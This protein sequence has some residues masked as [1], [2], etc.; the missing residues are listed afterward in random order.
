[1]YDTATLVRHRAHLSFPVDAAVQWLLDAQQEDGG[2][3]PRQVGY[4][5]DVPTLAATV[6]LRTVPGP[7]AAAAVGRA[8]EYLRTSL[9]AWR[10]WAPA[11][12]PTVAEMLVPGLVDALEP[13]GRRIARDALAAVRRARERHTS[14]L[15]RLALRPGQA[16]VHA[17]ELW[18]GDLQSAHV[19]LQDQT[20]GIGHSPGA[21]AAWLHWRCGIATRRADVLVAQDYLERASG[22]L[23]GAPSGVVPTVWPTDVLGTSSALYPLVLTGL[24]RHPQVAEAAAARVRFAEQLLGITGHGVGISSWM[25]PDGDD[26]A[27]AILVLDHGCQRPAYEAAWRHF[28]D[29]D[30]LVRAYAADPV[31][32]L[33]VASRFAHLRR[34]LHVPAGA[35]EAFVRDAQGPDGLWPA[36]GRNASRMFATMGALYG[37]SLPAAWPGWR[38]ALEAVLARQAPDGGFAFMGMP[39]VTETAQAALA[40]LR[41]REIGLGDDRLRGA[42]GRA[43]GFLARRWADG[44]GADAPPTWAAKELHAN[45]STDTLFH[46]G[47]LLRLCEERAARDA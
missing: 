18:P 27:L 17:W 41:L 25:E 37:L 20:G 26:T 36:A 6:A 8:L 23:T 32:S 5:R 15:R 4:W 24:L 35:L 19:H 40:L 44:R 2:W 39:S 42:L 45:R 29:A 30:G 10:E 21:T 28:S 22:A 33:A 31:P 3:H 43:R 1:V 7:G 11:D 47:A 13:E 46:L 38:Q 12:S 16:A 9:P 34:L 14:T